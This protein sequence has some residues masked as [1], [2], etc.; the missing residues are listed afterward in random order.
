MPK[1]SVIGVEIV[2]IA[3]NWMVGGR[4]MWTLSLYST[5]QRRLTRADAGALSEHRMR[6]DQQDL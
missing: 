4:D 1:S 2:A 6:S 5:E 3:G